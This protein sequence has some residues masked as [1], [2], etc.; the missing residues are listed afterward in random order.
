M[1][2]II[3]VI[4]LLIMVTFG[5]RETIKHFNGEGACCDGSSSIPKKKKLKN[6]VIA[7][8]E[9]VIRKRGYEAVLME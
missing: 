7:Y 1:T 6:K 5:I 9:A 3:I 4:I 2:N 8:I